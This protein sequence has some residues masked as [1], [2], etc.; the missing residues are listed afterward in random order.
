MKNAETAGKAVQSHRKA[1][2]ESRKQKAESRNPEQSRPKP[3]TCVVQA[4]GVWANGVA[5]WS[6]LQE[7]RAALATRLLEPLSCTWRTPSEQLATTYPTAIRHLSN[8]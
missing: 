4:W 1:K 2:T 3:G 8:I 6:N 5:G 7:V